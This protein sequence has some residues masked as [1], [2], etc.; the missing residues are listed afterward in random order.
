MLNGKRIVVIGATG[1]VGRPI[2]RAV[3]EAG[4]RV[5]AV[6]RRLGPLQRLASD[7]PGVSLLD[8]DAAA[9]GAPARVFEQ[10]VPDVLVLCAGA[11]PPAA[12]I[13]ELSWREFAVHV[14][15]EVRITFEF[16][17][18]ALRRP[19]PSGAAVIVVA[20]AAAFS[21][22][23]NS[24]GHAGA[25]RTQVYVANYAQKESDRLGLGLR[26]AVLA[27]CLMLDTELG[28]HVAVGYAR[29]LGMPVAEFQ[30]CLGALPTASDVARAVVALAAGANRSRHRVFVV[31]NHRLETAT[32]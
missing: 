6:A 31:S 26:F 8:L 30:I 3:A 21:G 7:V 10:A 15:A 2:V 16:C 11:W 9:D 32:P 27:P 19:L 12:P 25:Q 22:S 28:R 4:A 20:G 24:G 1:G 17:T 23:P 14:D 13:H 5:V 18:A 29:Y